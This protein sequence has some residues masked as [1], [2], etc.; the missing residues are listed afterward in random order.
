MAGNTNVTD[1]IPSRIARNTF[2]IFTMNDFPAPVSNVITLETGVYVLADNLSTPCSFDIAPNAIVEVLAAGFGKLIFYTG[3]GT[4]FTSTGGLFLG[5]ERINLDLSGNGAQLLDLDGPSLLVRL[6]RAEFTGTGGVLGTVVNAGE[7][8]LLSISQFIDFADG[9]S[10]DSSPRVQFEDIEFTTN[11]TG[12]TPVISTGSGVPDFN[13]DNLRFDAGVSEALFDIDPALSGSAII[14]HIHNENDSDFFA[15][16]S[17]D[18]ADPRVLVSTSPPQK[19]S[20]NKAG[21]FVNLN[22]TATTGIVNGVFQDCVFGTAGVALTETADTER[23]QMT[24]E[25]NGTFEFLGAFPFNG[26]ISSDI[27]ISSSGVLTGWRIKY[28]IDEGSGFVDLDDLV[29]MLVFSANA[30]GTASHLLPLRCVPGTL[31]KPQITR[32][33]GVQVPTIMNYV[34]NAF[35]SQGVI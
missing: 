33:N 6:M 31:L 7:S 11:D 15:A 14:D 23:W 25:I 20:A 32:V 18:E 8:A 5:L 12:S 9:F 17:L 30:T 13:A 35:A 27:A 2:E 21:G 26:Y 28:L 19:S 3:T 24:D 29:E 1:R 10:F 22:G 16:G 4:M 34:M